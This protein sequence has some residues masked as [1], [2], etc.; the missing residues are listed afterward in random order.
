MVYRLLMYFSWHLSFSLG[1]D[2]GPIDPFREP[3]GG[4]FPEDSGWRLPERFGWVIPLKLALKKGPKWNGW[5]MAVVDQRW[6][7]WGFFPQVTE[8]NLRILS[9]VFSATSAAAAMSFAKPE[10]IK[11]I[12]SS[13]YSPEIEGLEP[14]NHSISQ[15]FILFQESKLTGFQP[16]VLFGGVSFRRPLCR[17]G[18]C[19][20]HLP[21]PKPRA[22]RVLG[23]CFADVAWPS[24]QKILKIL[25]FP[26]NK[27]CPSWQH[28]PQ[29]SESIYYTMYCN[30]CIAVDSNNNGYVSTQTR[31]LNDVWYFHYLPSILDVSCYPCYISFSLAALKSIQQ[32]CSGHF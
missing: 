25:H 31:M 17:I 23:E 27:R 2:D 15:M 9:S 16:F 7:T 10:A 13:I 19:T 21:L 18:R 24:L 14:Q 12:K 26:S 8:V 22:K 29:R 4:C 11:F 30:I 32:F 20:Y 3:S 28:G 6:M 1:G 5:G